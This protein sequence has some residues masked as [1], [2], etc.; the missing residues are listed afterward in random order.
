M[1]KHKKKSKPAREKLSAKDLKKEV[2]SLFR[3][4]PKKQ[5]NPKQVIQ[6]LKIDTNKDA[7]AHAL[8]QLAEANQLVALPDFRFQL[9][10]AAIQEQASSRRGAGGNVRVG[11]VD[12]TRTGAAYIVSEGKEADVY[13]PAKSINTAMH[14]DRVEVRV[15]TPRGRSREEGEVVKVLERATEHFLGTLF[16]YPK[17]GIVSVEGKN[18]LEIMVDL[19]DLK[20]A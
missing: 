20:E 6:K 9:N 7:V 12:M 4:E 19:K 18:P 3:R 17:Y 15:W 8:N 2:L 11:V 13:V 16:L 10:R 5:L 1:T 14:G